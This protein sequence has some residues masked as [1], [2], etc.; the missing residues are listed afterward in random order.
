LERPLSLNVVSKKYDE[1]YKRQAVK[2]ALQGGKTVKQGG[3]GAWG[4][5]TLDLRVEE[6]KWDRR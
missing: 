6:E 1:A 3:R 5:P 2:M 4:K